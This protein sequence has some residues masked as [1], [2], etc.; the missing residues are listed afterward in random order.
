MPFSTTSLISFN[1]TALP[2]DVA[3]RWNLLTT[4]LYP[5]PK[6]IGWFT[7]TKAHISENLSFMLIFKIS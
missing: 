2:G 1:R 5:A 6:S 7:S 4:F 3:G